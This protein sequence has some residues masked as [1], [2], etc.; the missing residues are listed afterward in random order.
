MGVHGLGSYLFLNSVSSQMNKI[1]YTK[2]EFYFHYLTMK[3][4]IL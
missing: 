2:E 3:A 4:L 1:T